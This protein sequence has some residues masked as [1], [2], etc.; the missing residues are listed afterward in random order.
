MRNAQ[1]PDQ[2]RWSDDLSSLAAALGVTQKQ[3]RT[4]SPDPFTALKQLDLVSRHLAGIGVNSVATIEVVRQ[5]IENECLTL[6][7]QFWG[8]L[9]EACRNMGWDLFGSTN[10]RLVNKAVFILMEGQTVRIEGADSGY[11]P[12]VPSVMTALSNQLQGLQGSGAELKAFLAVIA[13]AYDALPRIGQACSLEALFR[14]C[15]LEAQKPSF[16]RN[17]STKSFTALT[18]PM[19]RYRITQLLQSG[20][21][22]PDGRSISLGT[23][24]MSKDVW[25]LYSPG[26]QRIV[27]AGRL[28]LVSPAS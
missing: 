21:S 4:L 5:K 12:F 11:T 10:R 19:F 27:Q 15:V 2:S 6:E 17:P 14:Q 16:W 22:T 26:E 7:T 1:I 23:T 25:E 13:K 18:R 28:S 20:L 24:T 9:S 8:I 3:L